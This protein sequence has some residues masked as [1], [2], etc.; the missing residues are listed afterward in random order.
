MRNQILGQLGSAL[1]LWQCKCNELEQTRVTSVTEE[2]LL[3][4]FVEGVLR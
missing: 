2:E 3:Q 4:D 1:L